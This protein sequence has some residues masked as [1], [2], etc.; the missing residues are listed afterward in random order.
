VRRA[1]AR[2]LEETCRAL[3]ASASAAEDGAAQRTRYE[4]TQAL[5]LALL[6]LDAP[7][8]T[9]DAATTCFLRGLARWAEQRERLLCGVWSAALSRC[10]ALVA[11]FG[12][13]G[14]SS[15]ASWTEHSSRTTGE[16]Y[17]R[18]VTTGEAVWE[19]P[20]NAADRVI[21]SVA[22]TDA[23]RTSTGGRM[24]GRQR[25]ARGAVAPHVEMARLLRA[26]ALLAPTTVRAI[27]ARRPAASSSGDFVV[28]LASL[29]GSGVA[30]ALAEPPWPSLRWLLAPKDGALCRLLLLAARIP[31]RVF[32]YRYILRVSCSQFDSLPLTYLTPA[33]PQRCVGV[34]AQ[35]LAPRR[36]GV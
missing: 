28:Y 27:A 31:R 21:A 5:L 13:R 26:L 6:R 24:F 9:V 36:G 1:A 32:M 34:C 20:A 12:S 19:K 2:A 17:W 30:D 23:P 4:R 18:S 35:L 7:S 25:S 8:A 11:A 29:H 33:H 3:A 10:E 22:E 14:A 16:T 15:A